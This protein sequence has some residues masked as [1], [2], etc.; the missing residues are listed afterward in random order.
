[1]R[2]LSPESAQ[3]ILLKALEYKDWIIAIG[4]DSSEMHNPPEKFTE[5]FDKAREYGFF[6][7]A[8]AGET[9]PPEYIWQAM[10]TLRVSR[11]GYGVRCTEDNDLISRMALTQIPIA[12]CPISN[13]KLGIVKSMKQ[14]PLKKMFDERLS[15]TINSDNPAYFSAYLNENY[16]AVQEALRFDKND[17]YEMARNSFIDS[18]L[19]TEKQEKYLLEL[20]KFFQ[21]S[22]DI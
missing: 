4:L 6:T 10:D 14:H 19:D 12:V 5:L 1:M 13:V 9:A 21:K 18:F 20:E 17:I 16:C 11:I 7:V 22:K 3:E 8:A 2:E 15:I